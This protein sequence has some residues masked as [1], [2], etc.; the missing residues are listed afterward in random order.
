MIAFYGSAVA[1]YRYNIGAVS[2]A[3]AALKKAQQAAVELAGKAKT[4][5]EAA[6]VAPDDQQ[7]EKQKAAQDTAAKQK[8]AEAAVTAA[9]N[10]LKNAI[11]KTKPKDIVDIIVSP[12]IT[13]RVNPAETAEKK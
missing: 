10:R 5:A 6:K 8:S 4:L 1:K 2:L 13:I 12:P 3:E 7:A 11:A 9:G